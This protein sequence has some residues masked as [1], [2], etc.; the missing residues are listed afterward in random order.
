M[1]KKIKVNDQI[2]ELS[3][4][5][6]WEIR[7]GVLWNLNTGRDEGVEGDVVDYESG[8]IKYH[9]HI[10]GYTCYQI[11]PTKEWG[12]VVLSTT[13]PK[14]QFTHVSKVENADE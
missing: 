3:S 14:P 12:G 8:G 7:K 4:S 9:G 11:I 2:I 6:R 10:D 5:C 1:V 13:D